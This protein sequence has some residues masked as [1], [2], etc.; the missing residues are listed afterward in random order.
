MSDIVSV[1]SA[2]WTEAQDYKIRKWMHDHGPNNLVV[3]MAKTGVGRKLVDLGE[4]WET[5]RDINE[6][7]V[8]EDV[9]RLKR[10]QVDL[11]NLKPWTEAED[12]PE[13]IVS[14]S[15]PGGVDDCTPE[16]GKDMAREND[17]SVAGV[18]YK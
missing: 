7:Y 18:R 4:E 3:Q 10:L 12:G 13:M 15:W 8:P 17:Q 5:R 16:D 9:Q 2:Y 6:W 14:N 1:L 11:L